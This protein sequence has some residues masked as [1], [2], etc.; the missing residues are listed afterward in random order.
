VL[1]RLC[2]HKFRGATQQSEVEATK[3]TAHLPGLDIYIIHSRSPGGDAEQLSINLHAGPSFQAFGRF[4]ETANPFVF[5]TEATR[6]FWFPW[7]EAAR[8]VMPPWSL[9]SP[10]PKASS[11]AVSPSSEEGH[12]SG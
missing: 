8:T 9:A 7:L 4:L 11:E 3:A 5:W 1:A 12:S 6:L 2:V 10:L